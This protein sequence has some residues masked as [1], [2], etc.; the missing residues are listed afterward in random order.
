MVKTDKPLD[1]LRFLSEDQVRS[2]AD[3]QGTPLFVYSRSELTV[4]AD[5]ILGFAELMPFGCTPRYAVKA[6][7]HPEIL[8]LFDTKGLYFDTSSSFE[9]ENCMKVGIS[10]SKILL[11][12]QQLPDNL[13]ELLDKGIQF[14]ATSLHQLEVFYKTAPGKTAG[15]RINPGMG[16]G[17]NNRNTTGG[18]STGFGIWHEYIPEILQVAAAHQSSIE[19]LH[20]HIGTGSDPV[21]WVEAVKICLNI[22]KQLPDV[23][24]LDIGGGFKAA[25]MQG[26]AE[27]DMQAVGGE[28]AALV[29][30][31]ADQT[32]RKL[33]I[34]IEPGRFLVVHAG[35]II[36]KVID[37]TDTGKNGY[38][39]IRTNTGMTEILRP[40]IYGAQHQLVIVSKSG[41]P[42]TYD[43]F[44]VVGH[45]CESSD[46]LTV[47]KDDPEQVEPRHLRIPEIG[48]YLVIEAAGAYCASMATVGYNAFPKAPEVMID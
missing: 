17:F 11:S 16:H 30:D 24:K 8:K 32:G 4:A 3:Q 43:D 41:R 2:R 40:A 38:K 48:D 7:E 22:V 10:G 29:Q 1:T 18:V 20:M 46:C 14:T 44:V 42:A 13:G 5:K 47:A 12:S 34:E 37:M 21:K 35:S 45:C 25:Y 19:R 23:T 36:A 26:D 9:A 39:F 31:F 6:N 27:T 15:V 28:I 33:R